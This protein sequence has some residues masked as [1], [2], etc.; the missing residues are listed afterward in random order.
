[1]WITLNALRNRAG[2]GRRMRLVD[3][4]ESL[5][6]TSFYCS[7]LEDTS[8]VPV[9]DFGTLPT[10]IPNDLFATTM[11]MPGPISVFLTPSFRAIA[12][13]RRRTLVPPPRLHQ[14]AVHARR[15]LL[16]VTDVLPTR[17][18]VPPVDLFLRRSSVITA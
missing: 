14:P 12:A 16:R 1:M 11:R 9:S 3:P 18:L 8:Q 4:R 2:G 10:Q 7:C 13:Q 6:S 17:S 5:D 15:R